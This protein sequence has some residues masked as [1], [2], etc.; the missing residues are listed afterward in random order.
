MRIVIK[1]RDLKKHTACDEYLRSPAWDPKKE[2]LVYEDLDA[3][4]QRL[5]AKE[6]GKFLR[7]LV[8]TGLIPVEHDH[9]VAAIRKANP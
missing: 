5:A 8:L 1:L 4:V 3:E 2:Q 9:A 7:W 6:G